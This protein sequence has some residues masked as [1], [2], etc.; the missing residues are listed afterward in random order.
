MYNFTLKWVARVQMVESKRIKQNKKQKTPSI[1]SSLTLKE[2]HGVIFFV[3]KHRRWAGG[4]S[5]IHPM[6]CKGGTQKD[7]EWASVRIN[8]SINQELTKFWLIFVY[9]VGCIIPPDILSARSVVFSPPYI[10]L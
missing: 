10:L 7:V 5:D 9:F 2:T 6:F 1:D 8:Q 3:N 4:M